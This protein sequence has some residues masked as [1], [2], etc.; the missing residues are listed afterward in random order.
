MK[1]QLIMK[2]MFGLGLMG[3]LSTAALADTGGSFSSG[4]FQTWATNMMTTFSQAS[5]IAYGA[6]LTIGIFCIMLGLMAWRKA[7]TAQGA[8]GDHVKNGG[9]LI[10]I[11]IFLVSLVPLTQMVQATLMSGAGTDQSMF[12]VDTTITDSGNT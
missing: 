5:T 10:A 4:N 12:T 3:G 6:A 2:S 7:H 1:K 11:G 8:Q 9:G